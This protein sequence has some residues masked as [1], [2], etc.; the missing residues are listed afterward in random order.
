MCSLHFNTVS[1]YP[2]S[3][4]QNGC[5]ARFPHREMFSQ[6]ALIFS[7]C[8]DNERRVAK[9]SSFFFYA[10]VVVVGAYKGAI[11]YSLSAS[12]ERCSRM[13]LRDVPFGFQIER[14]RKRVIQALVLWCRWLQISGLLS[15]FAV[16][17]G[18]SVAHV[19]IAIV[20]RSQKTMSRVIASWA[21][22]KPTGLFFFLS[23]ILFG[24]FHLSCK[25]TSCTYGEITEGAGITSR[26]I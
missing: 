5:F 25:N 4:E 2:P 12:L 9:M 6:M 11:I 26:I 20:G 21:T 7:D 1:S 16:T 24:S 22:R 14:R 19:I 23:Q 15:Y 18:F 8:R 17:T 3:A 10:V 13:E